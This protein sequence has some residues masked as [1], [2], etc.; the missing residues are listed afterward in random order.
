V[1]QH[2]S[3]EEMNKS[4]DENAQTNTKPSRFDRLQES[5]SS[6]YPFVYT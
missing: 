5:T 4:Q 6:K 2:I 1:V 3:T